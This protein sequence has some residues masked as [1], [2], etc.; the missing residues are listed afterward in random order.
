LWSG[1]DLT[2][3]KQS[4]EGGNIL[5]PSEAREQTISKHTDENLLEGKDNVVWFFF[6]LTKFK[7]ARQ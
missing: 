7:K 6:L 2:C 4:A 5:R 1:D 3:P